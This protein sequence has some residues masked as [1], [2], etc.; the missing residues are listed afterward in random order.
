LSEITSVGLAGVGL[1][2]M[3]ERIENFHGAFDITSSEKGACIR[4][5]IPASAGA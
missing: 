5:S 1:R 4:V 3:R 2:G